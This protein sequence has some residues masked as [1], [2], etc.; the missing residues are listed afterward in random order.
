MTIL[1]VA[2]GWLTAGVLVDSYLIFASDPA[3]WYRGVLT[4]AL[5]LSILLACVDLWRMSVRGLYWLRASMLLCLVVILVDIP[6]LGIPAGAAVLI[7]VVQLSVFWALNRY[8]GGHVQRRHSDMV[9][10][11]FRDGDLA[12]VVNCFTE[13]VRGHRRA[14]L[15][16]NTH[17][18]PLS[19]IS[20]LGGGAYPPSTS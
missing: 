16:E 17:G 4:V 6:T 8:V 14:T 13:S 15:W 11:A 5:G 2:L 20:T 18:H 12:G 7:V 1:C 10:R 9:I 3:L 19:R